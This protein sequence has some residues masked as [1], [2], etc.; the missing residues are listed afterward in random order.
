MNEIEKMYSNTG[1]K[2]KYS[3][4]LDMG[5][6]D[7]Q[8]THIQC[9][10]KEEWDECVFM[11]RSSYSSD[12]ENYDKPKMEYPTFTA[13]KQIEL[14]K[15]LAKGE[16]KINNEDGEYEFSIFDTISDFSSFEESLADLTNRMWQD[17]TE[18]ERKQIKEIL[19]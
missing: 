10:T 1:I 6:L 16:V 12:D 17:L 18:E 14:I 11:S 7:T 13:E 5:D 19:E 9:D 15:I 4:W 2:L 8:M 3:G